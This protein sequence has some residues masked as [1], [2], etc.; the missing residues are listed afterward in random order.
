[1]I[2]AVWAM[3]KKLCPD[4]SRTSIALA[5]AATLLVMPGA[6]VQVCVIAVG[7]FVGW[8]VYRGGTSAPPVPGTW[9]TASTLAWGALVAYGALL[10]GLPVLSAQAGSFLVDTFDAF[11]RSG[12][13]VFGGGH[14]VLPLL[15]AEV[16]PRGWLTDDHFL[17]GYG[18]A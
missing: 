11:Y 7:A 17:A 6:F 5:S 8:L 12:A 13:L 10:L 1:V 15:R 9:P 18:A 4:R 3:G 14:V 2:Q 16:V